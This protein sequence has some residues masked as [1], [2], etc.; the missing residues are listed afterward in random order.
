MFD[1]MDGMMRALAKKKTERKEN[2]FFA[3]KLARQKLSKYYTEVTPSTAMLLS[4]AHILDLFQQLQSFTKWGKGMDI[5]PDD[6]TSYTTQYQEA[7]LKYVENEYC[8]KHRRV[9]VN[10]L[11]S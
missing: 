7:F 5:I 1:H 3:V 10:K 2:L 8:A 9:P 4:C 6:K 11:Q